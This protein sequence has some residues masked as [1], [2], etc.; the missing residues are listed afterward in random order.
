MLFVLVEGAA[1]SDARLDLLGF[2][3][4]SL[5]AEAFSDICESISNG[6]EFSK[7]GIKMEE[8]GRRR[9]IRACGSD[10]GR[11]EHQTQRF[12]ELG[13][14]TPVFPIRRS[15]IIPSCSIFRTRR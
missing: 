3:D 14:V 12:C 6:L 8:I 2:G 7:D 11:L 1:S 9:S 13:S 4:L 5:P 10:S 15:Q